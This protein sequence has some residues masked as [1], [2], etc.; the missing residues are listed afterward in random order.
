M[1][2]IMTQKKKKKSYGLKKYFVIFKP[3]PSKKLS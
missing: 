1:E 3:V 2:E